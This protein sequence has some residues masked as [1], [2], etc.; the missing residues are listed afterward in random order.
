[1]RDLAAR[2]G[3][4]AG[5]IEIQSQTDVTWR[6]GSLGCPQPGMRYPQVLVDGY[7]IVLRHGTDEYPYHGRAG[8]PPFLCRRA[9]AP[10]KEP[11]RR[12]LSPK[13]EL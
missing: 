9:T 11:P 10:V 3:V 12:N 4:D 6:D 13:I 1:V 2:L 7:R 8:H 5:E